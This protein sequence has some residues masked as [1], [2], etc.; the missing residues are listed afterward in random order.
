MDRVETGVTTQLKKTLERLASINNQQIEQ[1]RTVEAIQGE[2]YSMNARLQ[3]LESKVHVIQTTGTS[4]TADNDFGGRK[5]ALI[6]G[7]WGDDTPAEETLNN[8]KQMVKDLRLDICAEQAFVP[9]VRRGFAILPY[10][11]KEGED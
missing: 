10:N 2:Q 7:G 9:G 6:M 8:V 1:Q 11:A 3:A 5:P 4:S